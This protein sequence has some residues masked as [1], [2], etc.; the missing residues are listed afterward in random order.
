MHGL[1]ELPPKQY[2]LNF[3]KFSRGKVGLIKLKKMYTGCWTLKINN[4]DKT[5][6]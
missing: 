1:R 2:S 5:C 6:C 4:F 3:H